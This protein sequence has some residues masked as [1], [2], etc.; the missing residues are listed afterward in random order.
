MS[1]H[2]MEEEVDRSLRDG[3]R[4]RMVHPTLVDGTYQDVGIELKYPSQDPSCKD[5]TE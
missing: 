3:T 2:A 4:R 1:V 5:I